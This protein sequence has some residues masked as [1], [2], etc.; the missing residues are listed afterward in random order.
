[1]IL[2]PA[3]DLMGGQVVRLRQGRAEERTVYGED[4]VAV[5]LRW[6]REGG[7]WLHLVDLDAAFGN[8]ADNFAAVRAIVAAAGIPCEL[9]GGMRSPEAVARALDAGVARVVIGTRAAEAPEFFA[10]AV[11]RFGADRIVAG[12]DAK[13][14]R[15]ALRGWTETADLAA[16]DLARRLEAAG[17]R[18]V[19][20]TDIATDGML[21]GPNLAGLRAMVAAFG[22][23]VIA[24]GGV[25]S[26]ADIEAL[27]AEE[28]IAGAIVGK[29]LYEST[30]SLP[31][32][33]A[34]VD[35]P[36]S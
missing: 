11:E 19:I 15:V 1:M 25:A 3:I 22:G 12:I 10:S 5:A 9:G 18:T 31:E 30:L 14:G 29:A 20:Y 35:R 23:E 16:T 24:S 4:P 8:G 27:A 26:L 13:D 17:A 7:H 32:A 36:A 21:T 34:A 33:R 6:E 2:L 28:G